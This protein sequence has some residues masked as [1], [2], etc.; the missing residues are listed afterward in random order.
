M[1]CYN[2]EFTLTQSET[3]L[4]KQIFATAEFEFERARVGFSESHN[5]YRDL[6]ERTENLKDYIFSN[7][8]DADEHK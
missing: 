3:I 1:K 8:V 5:P 4:L 2:F 6:V 7:S